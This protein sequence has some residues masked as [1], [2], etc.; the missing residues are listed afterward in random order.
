MCLLRIWNIDV[1]RHDDCTWLPVNDRLTG[2]LLPS[3]THRPANNKGIYK[4]RTRKQNNTFGTISTYRHWDVFSCFRWSG[5]VTAGFS[6]CPQCPQQCWRAMTSLQ[7]A[8]T[9][10]LLAV[11]SAHTAH[12]AWD[13]TQFGAGNPLSPLFCVHD[14]VCVWQLACVR[15]SLHVHKQQL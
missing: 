7:A 11:D 6:L 4:T 12:T 2:P 15:V 5:Y 9:D 10:K 14:S 1:C 3:K 13:A 8:G